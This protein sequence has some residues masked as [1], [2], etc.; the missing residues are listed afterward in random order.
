M[1]SVNHHWGKVQKCPKIF[2]SNIQHELYY[3]ITLERIKKIKT[4]KNEKK[5][6]FLSPTPLE[7]GSKH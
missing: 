4:E 3:C 2:M 6:I 7:N 5:K 1:T